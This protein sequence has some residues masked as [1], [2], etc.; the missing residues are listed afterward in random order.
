[1]N[2]F[3]MLSQARSCRS[4]RLNISLDSTCKIARFEAG[5][6]ATFCCCPCSLDK[7]RVCI[8]SGLFDVILLVLLTAPCRFQ[9]FHLSKAIDGGIDDASSGLPGIQEFLRVWCRHGV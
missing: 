6:E 8:L 3:L 5:D 1:M 9:L 7:I 4:D 2:W